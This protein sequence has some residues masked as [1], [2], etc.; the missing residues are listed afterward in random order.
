MYVDVSLSPYVELYSQVLTNTVNAFL[1]VVSS[2]HDTLLSH[3]V[4]SSLSL[5]PHPFDPAPT[6]SSSANPASATRIS[7]LISPPSDHA[8]YTR[9]WT[10]RSAV[11]KRASRALVTL[12]YVE[13][14]VEMIARK[15]GGD[16]IRWRLVLGIES[17]K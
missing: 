4:T 6:S 15:K 13:L 12:S 7:P 8:R 9:Y 16:R 17:L 3:R 11:Y 1:S 14:L 5:P 2:Y 10:D